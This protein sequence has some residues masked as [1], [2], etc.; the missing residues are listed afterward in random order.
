VFI[1]HYAL[2]FGA[3]RCAPAVSLGTL[4]LAC[5]FADLLW[6]TLVVLGVERVEVDPDNTV[7]TPLNFVSY[8][9]SHSLVMLV[10][11]SA[12]FALAYRVIKGWRPAAIAIVATLVFSHFVLDFVT[13]RPDLPL[14]LSGSRRVGLGLWNAPAAAITIEVALFAAG[15]AIYVVVTRARDRIG[16]IGL[17]TMIAFLMAIYVAALFGPPPPNASAVAMA[18]HLSWLFVAWAYWVDRHRVTAGERAPE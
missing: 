5:Q 12:L 4:F 3:K 1:G 13:H 11:W 6:P 9:Y 17:W 16:A 8:P 10:I 2:A 18:G 7:L 15:T 14:T